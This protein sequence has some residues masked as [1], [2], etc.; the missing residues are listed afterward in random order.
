MYYKSCLMR[1]FIVWAL[2]ASLFGVCATN[3]A[4]I[5]PDRTVTFENA[6]MFANSPFCPGDLIAVDDV[7]RITYTAFFN[8]DGSLKA[9]TTHDAAISSSVTDATTGKT[10]QVFYS[11]VVIQ[12]DTID[13]VTGVITITL[14][15]NGLNFIIQGTSGPPLVSAGRAVETVTLT[16]DSEGNP[17]LTEVGST[18]TPNMMHLTQVLCS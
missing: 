13:P 16:F 1:R 4:A 6:Y 15:F 11:N 12:R 8:R 18:A 9:F 2:V 14:G 5:A 17:T 7:G 10:L 3:A